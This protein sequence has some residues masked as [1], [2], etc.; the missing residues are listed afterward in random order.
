M[1][2]TEHDVQKMA[3]SVALSDGRL[4]GVAS[5]GEQQVTS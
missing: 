4:I 1:L 2:I 5:V 3:N